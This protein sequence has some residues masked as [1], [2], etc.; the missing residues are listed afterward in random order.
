MSTTW[1]VTTDWTDR[2]RSPE[3]SPGSPIVTGSLGG[4]ADS[5]VAADVGEGLAEV[6][7]ADEDGV[8][9]DGGA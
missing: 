4:V 9:G 7:A 3:T 8:Q 2:E 5:D 6:P 1:Y